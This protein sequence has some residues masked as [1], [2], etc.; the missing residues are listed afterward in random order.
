MMC[1]GEEL[2][3]EGAGFGVPIAKC[4]DNTYFSSTAQ[5]YLEQQT[6]GTAV[7]KKIF[8]LDA[9][10]KKQVR[11]ASINDSFYSLIHETFERAY[12]NRHSLRPVF[13][14]TMR[15]RKTLGVTTQFTRVPPRGK[16]TITYHCDPDRIKVSVD[17]SKLFRTQ[18]E[19][20]LLLNEQGASK[21]RRFS[22]TEGSVLYDKQIG[23]WAKVKAKK[24]TFSD[25]QQ[26]VSFSLENKENAMLIRGREQIQ[27]RFSWA[28]MTYSLNSKASFFDYVIKTNY[29]PRGQSF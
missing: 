20:I 28:G 6:A 18:C 17:L 13:D 22:D 29:S 5:L 9:V 8:L 24:A 12:L 21:F 23:A 14:W 7:F 15:L 27:D 10:S 16:V 26:T 3:E 2:I 19:E 11:G 25:T 4:T 1:R